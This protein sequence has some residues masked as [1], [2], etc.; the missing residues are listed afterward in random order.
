MPITTQTDGPMMNTSAM[1]SSSPGRASCAVSRKFT[2][3]STRPPKYPEI[4]PSVTPMNIPMV[5][6]PKPTA[7]EIRVP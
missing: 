7:R 6:A 3:W 5:A 1:A 2:P 4:T